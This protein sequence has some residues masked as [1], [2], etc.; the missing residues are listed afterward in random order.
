MTI[1][2]VKNPDILA[3]LGWMD[4]GLT[5]SPFLVGF[6]AETDAL[7]ENAAK[8]LSEK[9]LDMIV[10]NDVSQPD[11]GFNVDTNRALLLFKDGSSCDCGLMSK[12]QLAGTILD[13]IVARLAER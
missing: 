3:G 11:A 8:K 1:E 9:K 4:G 10:A 12:D 13:H 7:A 5:R 2:L 6:A